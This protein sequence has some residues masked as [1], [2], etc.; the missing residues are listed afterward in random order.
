MA[1]GVV[2]G[3]EEPLLPPCFTT[4]LPVPLASATVS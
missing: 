1:E 3:Q 4:A 2:G